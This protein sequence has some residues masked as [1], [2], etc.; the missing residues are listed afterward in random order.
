VKTFVVR[1][2]TP[3]AELS[4]TAPGGL[5]GSVERIRSPEP[6]QFRSGEELLEILRQAIE[7]E[8]QP[9]P[10]GRFKAF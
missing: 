5:H 6:A 9:L 8:A 3:D 4:D 7:G 10:S 2:W 1:I